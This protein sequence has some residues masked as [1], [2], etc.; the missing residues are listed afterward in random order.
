MKLPSKTEITTRLEPTELK[1]LKDLG[2]YETEDELE[3]LFWNCSLDLERISERYEP[4]E[5]PL[6]FSYL[7]YRHLYEESL[8]F[9]KK[10][11][12]G[13]N[14]SLED[15]IPSSIKNL[16]KLKML[17]LEGSDLYEW[18]EKNYDTDDVFTK[19]APLS[20]LRYIHV[21]KSRI[22]EIPN[23]AKMFPKLR[24]LTLDGTHLQSTPKWLFDFA[25]KHNARWY[26]REGV[27]KGDAEVLGL[28][29]IMLR[30]L[31]SEEDF[32][33]YSGYSIN[34]S[35]NVIE[36]K[37]GCWYD[38]FP[39]MYFAIPY[40]PE[41]ISHL[42]HLERL[43]INVDTIPFFGE[44]DIWIPESKS[45]LKSLRYLC[46][47]AKYSER[48]LPYL[49][50]LERFEVDAYEGDEARFYMQEPK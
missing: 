44:K 46:T 8:I 12:I 48:L 35:G 11:I 9:Q 34:D 49:N 18:S 41:E 27:V 6:T 38:V 20:N 30:G 50:S 16:K 7:M 26:T 13:L 17:V 22:R 21:I 2:W 25:Q 19:I 37:L 39:E 28:L 42:Q 33:D 43:Y 45:K 4:Y 29:G 5:G 47:S 40:I 1:V 10:H 15:T 23:L 3:S 24:Y 36:L 31:S 32:R 14:L